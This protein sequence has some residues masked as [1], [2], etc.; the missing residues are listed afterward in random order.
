MIKRI[1]VLMATLVLGLG[2]VSL[3]TAAPA[4]AAPGACAAYLHSINEYTTA[5]NVIC[6]STETSARTLS[7][8]VA[9]GHCRT[10]MEI[11]TGL[12]PNHAY[13]ACARAVS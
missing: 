13:E 3:A 8:Q 12:A 6:A 2:G 9:F 1:F 5:R 4:A 11:A 7:P 10:S